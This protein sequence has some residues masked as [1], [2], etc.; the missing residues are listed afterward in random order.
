MREL[1]AKTNTI[2]VSDPV[3]GDIHVFTY[4]NPTNKERIKLQSALIVK[5]GRK[6]VVTA[7]TQGIFARFTA[8]ILTGF[9]AGTFA[10]DGN[11]ISSDPDDQYYYEG[12]KDLLVEVAPDILAVIGR[13]L[14]EGA[15][16][17]PQGLAIEMGDPD[18][19]E[20]AEDEDQ[21]E[22][23]G[24]VESDAQ[25]GNSEGGSEGG[26]DPLSRK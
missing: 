12:W 7:D 3:S 11:L 17:V 5:S 22:D 24:P 20:Q 13:Q 2:E 6:I 23:T 9:V 18:G 10:V 15:K 16:V 26:N 4:R 25:A 1:K 14:F 8:S 19:K 21:A